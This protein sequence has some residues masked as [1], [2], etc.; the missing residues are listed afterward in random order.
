[1]AL[2][3]TKHHKIQTPE[4]IKKTKRNR[5]KTECSINRMK[6]C[7]ICGSLNI[8]TQGVYFC[9][10]CDE[11]IETL[12][13]NGWL[14]FNSDKL[15]CTCLKTRIGHKGKIFHYRDTGFIEVGKCLDCGAVRSSFCPN[16]KKHKCWKKGSKKFCQCGF[17]I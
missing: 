17:R 14:Y 12:D 7:G 11:E 16:C 13:N 15:E 9:N 1:M 5:R 8:A 2:E 3:K 6:G 4:N 10:I